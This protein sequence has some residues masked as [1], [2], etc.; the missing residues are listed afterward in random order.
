MARCSV[1]IAAQPS[2]SLRFLYNTV[3]GRIALKLLTR[4]WV[5]RLVG[6]FMSC[7]L[8]RPLIRPFIRKNH[9][10]MSR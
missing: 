1:E 3:P 5:S 10:D 7:P 9:I 4:V 2:A 8:S 6:A